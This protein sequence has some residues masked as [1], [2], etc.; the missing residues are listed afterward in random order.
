[1]CEHTYVLVEFHSFSPRGIRL[2]ADSELERLQDS[3]TW[4]MNVNYHFKQKS[5]AVN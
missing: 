5:S 2:C 1:M 4:E 3:E